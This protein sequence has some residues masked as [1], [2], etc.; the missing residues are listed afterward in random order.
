MINFD[1]CCLSSFSFV[2]RDSVRESRGGREGV[3][4]AVKALVRLLLVFVTKLTN[5][6]IIILQ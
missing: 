4:E 2:L 1:H 6:E 3:V 5:M